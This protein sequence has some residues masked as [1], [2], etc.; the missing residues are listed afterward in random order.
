MTWNLWWRFGPWE[1][2]QQA[3]IDTIRAHRPDVVCLQEVWVDG[4][5]DL[6]SIIG[7]ELGFHTLRSATIGRGGVIASTPNSA[8]VRLMMPISLAITRSAGDM[9]LC[10]ISPPGPLT[11]ATRSV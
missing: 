3:I 1:Q 5:D 9:A 10:I 7:S 11:V 6:A 8:N 4:S 2:R